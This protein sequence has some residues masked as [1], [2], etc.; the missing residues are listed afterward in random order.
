MQPAQNSVYTDFQGLASL[1]QQSKDK[2]PEVLRE[3][4]KQFEAI[5]T[6]MML[7][8]MRQASQG[9]GIFESKQ[10]EFYRDM[11]D[12]QLSV[13]L[14]AGSGLGLADMIVQQLGG[15]LPAVKGEEQSNIIG[16]RLEDYRGTEVYRIYR[17]VSQLSVAQDQQKDV[18]EVGVSRSLTV[19]RSLP[20][21][22]KE[23]FIRQLT[24]HAEAVGKKLGVAPGLLV[25]QAAL[26]TGWGKSIIQNRDGSSS[27]NL[28]GIKADSRWEGEH[29]EASTLEYREGVAI[30]ERAHF[31][32]YESFTESFE[33]YVNF[34]AEQPRYAKALSNSGNP[35]QF[36]F[37]LQQAGYATDPKYAEKIVAIYNR[38]NLAS[39]EQ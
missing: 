7:K 12:Q 15:Q 4:A 2:S 22:D 28:F 30:R 39:Q 33:D 24:P 17:E 1:R 29:T 38:E 37:S 31:R 16:K 27:H 18:E 10:S 13:H 34:L 19:E 23:S 11:Y 5:F 25:A 6:Q 14:S 32:S 26:E 8:S 3:V 9:E 35:E 20:I 36:A 21:T